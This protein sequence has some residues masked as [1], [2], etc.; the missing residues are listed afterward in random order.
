MSDEVCTVPENTQTHPI[1]F[2]GGGGLTNQK[3]EGSMRFNWN[4]RRVEE[5]WGGVNLKTCTEGMIFLEQHIGIWVLV[6]TLDQH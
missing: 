4:F 2:P 6:T 3:F 5:G 1:S